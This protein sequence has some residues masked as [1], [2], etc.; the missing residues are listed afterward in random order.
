[1][2]WRRDGSHEGIAT[3]MASTTFLL[4]VSNAGL[5][6]VSQVILA[7]WMGEHDYGL[8]AYVWTW[9]LLLG[10]LASLGLPTAIQRL[11][12]EYTE[13][14]DFDRLR[15]VLREG[16]LLTLGTSILTAG[17]A[18]ALLWLSEDS[19]LDSEY[20]WPLYLALVCV[21]VYALLEYQEGIARSYHWANL[22]FA[23]PYLYRPLILLAGLACLAL[24]GITMS[25]TVVMWV[26][27]AS[28]V[29][30]GIGQTVVLWRKLRKVVPAGGHRSDLRYWMTIAWPLLLIDGFYLL[31]TY[32][33]VL[34]LQRFVG[35]NEV[36]DYFAA[37]KIM[38]ILSFVS[39]A[40]STATAPRFAQY[41]VSG[42]REK[43]SSF[44]QD[45][46]RWTFWPSV[47][48]A[49]GLLVFGEWL[50]WLFGPDFVDSY[51]LLPLIAIGLVARAA[52]GPVERLLSMAGEQKLTARI[53]A[54][55]LVLNIVLNL[56]L[57]PLMGVAGAAV[58]TSI[59]MIAQSVVMAIAARRT[60][61]VKVF[62]RRAFGFSRT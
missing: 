21:P 30:A 42:E 53:H 51:F 57:I 15:G 33:D 49:I 10:G 7:R 44:L 8:Y 27:L 40:V 12:P 14:G 22:A 6:L 62:T 20:H 56:I 23:P 13:R 36:A 35:P 41:A 48:A 60:L 38:A 11:V 50:L 1:M 34:I 24:L 58:A 39:F 31:L 3:R 52:V 54:G 17:S 28:I 2:A 18:C 9:L 19:F 16:S 45:S 4:R 61:G 47:A 5:A 55:T 32:T 43:L 59:A 25:A 29:V 26:T 37:T 46:I